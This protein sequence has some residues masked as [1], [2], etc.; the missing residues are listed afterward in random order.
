MV[1]ILKKIK[2]PGLRNYLHYGHYANTL[3]SGNSGAVTYTVVMPVSAVDVVLTGTGG[4]GLPVAAQVAVK[5]T[6]SVVNS[7]NDAATDAAN[8]ATDAANYAADAADAA[9]TAAQEATA[10]AVAAQESADAA[11]AAVVALGLRVDT[12]LASVRAQLTSLSNLLVRIIRK[13]KA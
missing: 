5:A 2:A 3:Y 6:A 11:T 10:A 4:T 9:T 7:A 8:A 1:Y 13:T 12:L